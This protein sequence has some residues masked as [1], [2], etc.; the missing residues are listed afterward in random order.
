MSI[1][2]KSYRPI[3]TTKMITTINT[4]IHLFKLVKQGFDRYNRITL[5]DN[6]NLLPAS[7]REDQDIAILS[8]TEKE[9]EEAFSELAL[10]KKYKKKKRVYRKR[11]HFPIIRSSYHKK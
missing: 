11:K 2:I 9:R 3:P 10:K 8:V 1:S 6:I 7:Y 4:T 5:I